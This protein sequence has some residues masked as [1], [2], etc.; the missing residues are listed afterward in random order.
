MKV[1]IDPDR[2]EGHLRC[3]GFAPEVFRTDEQGHAF[4]SPSGDEVPT[5]AEKQ[6]RLA[7]GNCPER[8]ITIQ[9]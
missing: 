9:D 3:V 6:T 5:E 2:C 1:I 4:T 8:A 7:A